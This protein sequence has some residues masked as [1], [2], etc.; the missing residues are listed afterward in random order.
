MLTFAVRHPTETYRN[1]PGSLQQPSKA[2]RDQAR[3]GKIPSFVDL[4]VCS[5]GLVVLLSVLAQ[6]MTRR[7]L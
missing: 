7:R 4:L 3:F 1:H 5:L 2:I 6:R